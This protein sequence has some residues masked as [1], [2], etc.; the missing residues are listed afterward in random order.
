MLGRRNYTQEELDSGK[1]AIAQQ[2][3]A[4]RRLEAAVLEAPAD[5]D[6][7]AALDAFAPLFFNNLTLALDRQFC[8]AAT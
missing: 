8:N 6:A 3:E 1:T 4:Y 7:R 5:S 2:L